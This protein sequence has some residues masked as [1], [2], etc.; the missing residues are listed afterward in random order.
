[1]SVSATFKPA[2]A[3][4]RAIPRRTPWAAPVTR[5]TVREDESLMKGL[6]FRGR[7]RGR[8]ARPFSGRGCFQPAPNLFQ[9]VGHDD[10]RPIQRQ[11]ATPDAPGVNSIPER[12]I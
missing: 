8:A 3:K 12:I 11:P 5:A 7:D 6:G 9:S 10:R 2:T 4:A 1:M